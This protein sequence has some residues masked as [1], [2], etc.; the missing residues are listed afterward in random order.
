M[1]DFQTLVGKTLSDEEF[2]AALVESPEATLRQAGIEPTDEMLEALK[3]ID[4][5]AVKNLAATFGEDKAAL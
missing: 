1:S 5:E 4:V 3:G 2:A